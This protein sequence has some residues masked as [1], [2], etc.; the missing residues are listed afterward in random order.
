MGAVIDNVTF[1]NEANVDF[2]KYLLQNDSY[3]A[4]SLLNSTV[5][6]GQTGTNV[7]DML[8]ILAEK[9]QV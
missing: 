4:M 9:R 1:Q 2:K 8:L 6:V 3:T 7:N 5:V